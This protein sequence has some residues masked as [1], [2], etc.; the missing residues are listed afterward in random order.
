VG[1]Y[2]LAWQVAEI[3]YLLRLANHELQLGGRIDTALA[4]LAAA[5]GRL[6]ALGEPRFVPV[7]EAIAREKDSLRAVVQPDRTGKALALSSLIARVDAL[8]L[9]YGIPERQRVDADTPIGEAGVWERLRSRT[10]G[11]F[12]ELV[13]VRHE[14]MPVRPLLAPEQEYFLRLNLKLK[15]ESARLALLEDDP[16]VW[17]AALREARDWL[18]RWF[19]VDETAVSSAADELERLAATEIRPQ[20]PDISR[21]LELLRQRREAGG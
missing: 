1:L 18:D 15:L 13:T 19:D 17:R 7:R 12:R 16:V 10:T 4:A 5:D 8:A 6:A 14:D 20:R 2:H 11:I 21:S 9:A 3:E